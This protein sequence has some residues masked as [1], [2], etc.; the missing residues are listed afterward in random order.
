MLE[1]R[2]D[3]HHLFPK[4]YLIKNGI[5]SKAMYNQIANYVYLQSEINI[6]IKDSAPC[7]YMDEVYRQCETKEPIY[8]GIV[9]R[10]ILL[11]NL[12]E[13]CVPEKFAEMDIQNYS[14]FLEERRKLMAQKI[15][16]FYEGL[17]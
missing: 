4:E 12:K 16:K 8:G 14:T 2:G 17:K 5:N 7:V 6:K 10:D 11:E 13:N 9:D 1:H 3:I 15:R